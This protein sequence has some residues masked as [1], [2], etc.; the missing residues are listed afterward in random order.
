MATIVR[1]DIIDGQ[2]SSIYLQ[3][4]NVAISN[5]FTAVRGQINNELIVG[6][7][8]T[9]GSLDCAGGATI[10]GSLSV[11]GSMSITSLSAGATS[12]NSLTCSTLTAS[13]SASVASLTTTSGGITVGGNLTPNPT[14]FRNI[15][16]INT[17]WNAIY[18]SALNLQAGNPDTVTDGQSLGALTFYGYDGTSA[19]NA[20][21]IRAEV[22]N[23]V[24]SGGDV[25]AA[26]YFDVVQDGT[27]ADPETRYRIDNQGAHAMGGENGVVYAASKAV[28]GNTIPVFAGYHSATTYNGPGTGTQSSAIWTSG[29]MDNINGVY[30]NGLSDIRVKENVVDANS[31]WDDIK[32]LRMVNFNFK[33]EMGYPTNK[34]LG[35]IAQEVEAV[36]P[37]L[38]SES[39][40]AKDGDGKPLKGLKTSLIYLK[41]VK[42]L[43]E[44]M[45]RI[46]VLEQKLADAGI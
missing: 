16:S 1:A 5:G 26:L 21:A 40:F 23:P 14:K 32:A 10:G 7:K 24:G 43:Q 13:S 38:V 19:V 17:R 8:V 3:P 45:A 11:S 15:G 20:A 27:S 2:N 34:Q 36:S 30:G 41:A 39:G 44:A 31:Q 22:D 29:Q 9:A 46:E 28:S 42:A 35:F 37:D 6:Q 33:E 4:Q 25:P 18:A 12:V